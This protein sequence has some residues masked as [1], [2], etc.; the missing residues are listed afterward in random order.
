MSSKQQ[1]DSK[2]NTAFNFDPS[3]MQA[4]LK[5]I[6]SV[7][8]FL[9]NNVNNPFGNDAFKQEST[10]GQDQ[11]ARVGQR[12]VSNVT[13]NAAGLGYNTNG[14]M[15]NSMLQRAGQNTSA[16]QGQAFRGA[17]GNAVG[18]QMSSAGMLSSFQP[19][20]TGSN[21][22]SQQTQQTSGLGTW[23]PQLIGS[24]GGA[25]MSAFAPGAGAAM[26]AG[27]AASGGASAFSGGLG[28]VFG[29]GPVGGF[30]GMGAGGVSGLSGLFPQGMG[31]VPQFGGSSGSA[32]GYG[33]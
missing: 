33:K 5:N 26:G 23:L 14:G 31:G 12:G 11:A 3:S 29:S 1:T 22:N 15:F 18:R 28:G 25:A 19:L 6:S 13:Q 30:P 7:M 32:Y 9:Q 10:I 16:M 21:S 17:I 27:K 24:L 4:Y 8:P 2:S 20:M